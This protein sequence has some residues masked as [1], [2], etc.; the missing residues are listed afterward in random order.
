M[1]RR[2]LSHPGVS[3]MPRAARQ[4]AHRPACTRPASLTGTVRFREL[5]PALVPSFPFRTWG[6]L[7]WGMSGLTPSDPFS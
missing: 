4:R 5:S 3:R 7:R 1:G 6:S 2:M